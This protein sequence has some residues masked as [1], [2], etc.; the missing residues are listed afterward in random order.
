MN[1]IIF[2]LIL[3]ILSEKEDLMVKK[4]IELEH[5]YELTSHAVQ[6]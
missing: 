6:A 2:K 5:E 3:V 1:S 4:L